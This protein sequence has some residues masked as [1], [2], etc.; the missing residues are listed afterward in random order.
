M[1]PTAPTSPE[2]WR[3][4]PP[5]DRYAR[6]ALAAM[7]RLLGLIDKNPFS[8]AFGSFDRAWWHYRTMDFPCGMAQEMVLPLALAYAWDLP[9]GEAYRG[10]ERVRELVL[11]ALHNGRTRSHRDGTC[12]DYFPFERAMGAL[13]FSL[14][15]ATESCLALGLDKEAR[16]GDDYNALLEFFARRGDHLAKVNETGQLANHQAFAALA[17]RNVFMLTGE[18]RYRRAADERLALTL[19]W[20]DPTAGSRSTRAPIPATTPARS[21]SWRSSG[22]KARTSAFR[23]RCRRRS[24]SRIASC[25]RTA[26]TPASMARGTPIT[27]TRTASR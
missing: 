11:G 18:E 12:D 8:P 19:S 4:I 25:T 6:A 24:A 16:A 1:I 21:P 15:A 9:G 20:Q 17:L 7:P 3:A 2:L 22:R 23:R 10:N 27:S 5:R 26:A 14:Y 13:V